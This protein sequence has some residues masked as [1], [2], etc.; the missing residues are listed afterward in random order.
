MEYTYT[1]T[2]T[3]LV[4]LR[5]EPKECLDHFT[6]K[7]MDLLNIFKGSGAPMDE[8]NK[9][10]LFLNALETFSHPQNLR[11]M[12]QSTSARSGSVYP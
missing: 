6:K 9:V 8:R 11:A 5:Q 4:N 1:V 10:I 2:F 12:R 3:K 7:F